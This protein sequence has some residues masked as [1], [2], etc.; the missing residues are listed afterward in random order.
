MNGVAQ[1]L[2]IFIIGFIAL[3]SLATLCFMVERRRRTRYVARRLT[4]FSPDE[5][6]KDFKQHGFVKDRIGSMLL[7]SWVA[8]FGVG[9]ATMAIA[10]LFTY[11]TEDNLIPSWPMDLMGGRESMMHP[12]IVLFTIVHIVGMFFT[13]MWEALRTRFMIP[14]LLMSEATHVMIE[15]HVPFQTDDDL[16]DP[17]MISKF[18]THAKKLS[19]RYQRAVARTVVPIQVDEIGTRHLEYTCVRYV[20]KYETDRFHPEGLVTIEP[21][22]AHL[23][24][25]TGGLSSGDVERSHIHCGRNEINVHV[26]GIL[27][28]LMNEFA[29]FTYLT[30]SLAVWAYMV[31]L[32]WN[33]GIFWLLLTIGSGTARS[34]F[35]VRPNK[36]KIQQLAQLHVRC[37]VLRENTWIE[38][39]ASDIALGDIV[40]VEDGGMALPCDGIVVAGSLV[41]NE[42]MLTGEP[43]PIQKLPVEDSGNAKVTNKNI[44]YAGTKCLQSIGPHEGKAVII[45]TAVGALTT[46]GQLVR[47]VLFPATVRFKYNDQ[48]P[49]V[50]GLMA[51]YTLIA[52]AFNTHYTEISS[53]TALYMM[54]VNTMAQCLS[55]MLPVSMVMGQSVTASRLQNIHKIS[56]LQPGRIPIAGKIQMM[57]FDKTGTITKDGMDFAGAAP[58]VDGSFLPEV[59]LDV[60]ESESARQANSRTM[61][62]RVPE[63]FRQAVGCCHSVTKLRDGSLVGNQVEVSMVQ[64]SGWKLDDDKVISPDGEETI[65]VVRRLEFD[66][67]RMTSGVVVRTQGSSALTVHMKGSYEVVQK[68]CVAKTVPSNYGAITEGYAKNGY[69]VLGVASRTLPA[70]VDASNLVNMSRDDLESDLSLTGLLL[71]KNEMKKDSAQAIGYL[72]RARI[73]AVICTGDNALTGISVGRRCGIVSPNAKVLLAEVGKDGRLTWRDAEVEGGSKT[74]DPWTDTEAELAVTQAGWRYLD[75]NRD[76]L[77]G[78]WPRLVVYARMKPE[79]K[80]N[81]IKYFQSQDLVTGMCGDGGNDCGSLRAAHAGIALSD[82]E[83]SMVSPF[84]TGRD[85]KSL[86]TV[87][88]LIREG[89]ACLSTNLAT[90]QYFIVYAVVVTFFK[91]YGNARAVFSFSEYIWLL[92]DIAI[93]ISMV[94]TM[95]QSQA[96]DELADYRPT[97]TLLGP[98][99]VIAIVFPIALSFLVAFICLQLL[100]HSDWYTLVKPLDL[101]LKPEMWLLRADSYD[102]ALLSLIMVMALMDTAYVNTY[103]GDF[104]RPIYTN[105]GINVCYFLGLGM[106]IW[107]L[108]TGPSRFNCIFRINCDTEYSLLAGDWTLLAGFSGAGLIGGCFM[109]PQVLEIQRALNLSGYPGTWIPKTSENCL[110]PTTY[111]V[112]F[113]YRGSSTFPG[114][115]TP[116]CVGPNNCFDEGLKWRILFVIL[117][118]TIANH[119]FS[120]FLLHGTLAEKIRLKRRDV[121]ESLQQRRRDIELPSLQERF[122]GASST[123]DSARA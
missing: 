85:G 115:A 90:F 66:H 3:L 118:G 89:R 109:G 51:L 116:T 112:S 29:D 70:S 35:I 78:L 93:S 87:I 38:I 26:P 47:M 102:P 55:P 120:K 17:D 45:A 5:S 7:F 14:V 104:R 75:N 84:A 96:A 82:A 56:V 21:Q 76:I 39:E 46:R 80:I 30:N 123:R 108:M 27:E 101:G 60:G 11:A 71:F 113:E 67:C 53:F 111:N 61:Q 22:K 97:A 31:T 37:W 117:V 2:C 100:W 24:L 6:P 54:C 12:W 19:H 88:D 33:I 41:V 4:F 52:G 92:M 1:G 94:W 64:T 73:R 15:E 36:K 42:S 98:R 44:A 121:L 119:V 49:T 74:C 28:A 105:I 79:D 18:K 91:V 25:R 114:S 16:T 110:P 62:T 50:Y 81:V 68:R 86:I 9:Y 59:T 58:V 23:A 34:L 13:L 65:E 20:Y 48:L 99:T 32:A 122:G 8:F 69:Y 40:K 83:A 95:T 77:D 106:V 43:M 10:I 107:L 72:R 103:G 63:P 57:V